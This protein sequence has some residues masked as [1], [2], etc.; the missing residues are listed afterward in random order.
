MSLRLYDTAAREVRDFEPHAA[1]FSPSDDKEG[2]A[3]PGMGLASRLLEQAAG[4]RPGA[5]VVLEIGHGQ[6]EGVRAAGRRH[7]W[8][9]LRVIPDYAG[10]PRV[11]GSSVSADPIAR[12]DHQHTTRP[13]KRGARG[14]TFFGSRD[15]GP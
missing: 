8:H 7:G 4:L 14:W 6:L 2:G 12:P 15:R 5:E 3:A 1:L 11:S 10:I 13:R 9:V